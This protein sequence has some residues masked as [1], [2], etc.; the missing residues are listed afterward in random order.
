MSYS[1]ITKRALAAVMKDLM[2]KRPFSKINVGDI[3]AACGLNRK[4]FYYHFR[5]KY[6]LVNWIFQT[7]FITTIQTLPIQN[8]W[9]LLQRLC[10]YFY[11][12]RAFYRAALE[13]HGQNS[14]PEYFR[15]TMMPVVQAALM[16]ILDKPDETIEDMVNFAAEFYADAFLCSIVRWLSKRDPDPADTFFCKLQVCLKLGAHRIISASPET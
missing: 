7:E 8:E 14:F 2:A 15:E 5:D 3:C 16:G 11:E 10:N 9:E 1:D 13:V 6:D 12:N 4:S